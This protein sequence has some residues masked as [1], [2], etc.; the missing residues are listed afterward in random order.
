[1]SQHGWRGREQWPARLSVVLC[2]TGVT[3]GA[4]TVAS[5]YAGSED[6]SDGGCNVTPSI[7][8][9]TS[10]SY[11]PGDTVNIPWR[12]PGP[13]E[14]ALGEPFIILAVHTYMC[15]IALNTLAGRAG[16]NKQEP[17]VVGRIK[18]EFL[19]TH[20]RP[21][22][23]KAQPREST[24]SLDLP[25]STARTACK[26]PHDISML[27]IS[28]RRSLCHRQCLAVG[29]VSSPAVL[30]RMPRPCSAAAPITSL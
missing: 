5:T 14:L 1:M 29:D 18:T 11:K 7:L 20:R 26:A 4:D 23:R 15:T 3:S 21:R 12:P 24:D 22:P 8:R 13:L 16:I 10:T 28:L 27:T 19:P 17:V 30:S 6:G 25:L 2:R 9:K